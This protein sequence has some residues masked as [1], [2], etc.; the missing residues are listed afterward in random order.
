MRRWAIAL[1]LVFLAS[2][3]HAATFQPTVNPLIPTQNSPLSS[4]P[5]RNN[6]QYVYN[7]LISVAALI[8]G[9]GGG[10][11]GTVTSVTCSVTSPASCSVA[12]STTTPAITLTLPENGNGSLFQMAIGSTTSGDITIFDTNG[13]TIDGLASIP[14]LQITWPTS[15]DL[16]LSSATNT[17]TGL[18]EIDGDCVKGV[19]GSWIAGS[20]GS[21]SG[22]TLANTTS[23]LAY[24]FSF[25]TTTNG[26]LSTL[27]GTTNVSVNPST[28][29]ISSLGLTTTTFTTHGTNTLG[30]LTTGALSVNGTGV[31]SSG[32]LANSFLTNSSV[33]VIGGTNISVAGG[34]PASLGGTTTISITGQVGVANGGTG[35]ATLTAH[36]V[37]IGEGTSAFAAVAQTTTPGWVLTSTTTDPNWQAS[38]GGGSGT[39]A[40]GTTGQAAVYTGSTTVGSS[41]ALYLSATALGVLTTGPLQPLDVNGG[42]YSRVY[43]AGTQSSGG[44][45]TPNFATSN[46]ITF[47][48][49]A[50]NLTIANPTNIAAGQNYQIA[51]IQDSVGGRTITWGSDFKW[52]GGTAPTLS[53]GVGAKDII[54]CWA[55]TTSTLNCALAIVN[56]H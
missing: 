52:G 55:D 43:A 12:T 38:S 33:T 25:T 20:C 51:A 26:S 9:G 27:Y 42:A 14:S 45:L 16:L 4:L 7:D 23:N 8:T 37:L 19:T 11:S 21:G 35:A 50:G 31:V 49:G 18:V 17:P 30:A 48:F 3:A 53:T 1:A 5:I 44:T 13:N 40:S 56:A 46:S 47:T 15:G 54:S 39:V 32:T 2:S 6:F 28:S 10:G 24:Y 22:V 29:V 34:G 41:A 36:G